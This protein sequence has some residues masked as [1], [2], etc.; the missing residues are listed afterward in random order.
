MR[1]TGGA[2]G[3]DVLAMV[4]ESARR[5]PSTTSRGP[6]SNGSEPPISSA[7]TPGWVTSA[8]LGR[9]ARRLGVDARGNL[10]GVVHGDR[11]FLSILRAR[12][13]SHIVNTASFAG[14]LPMPEVRTLPGSTPWSALNSPC[15][16]ES[17][18]SEP[19]PVCPRRAVCRRRQG[20][21]R[22]QSGR[23]H[24]IR[25]TRRVDARRGRPPP[26]FGDQ[27]DPALPPISPDA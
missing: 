25:D 7:T 19:A 23:I 14:T 4:T 6:L 21:R 3:D 2:A 8:T 17:S 24:R 15:S 13:D 5:K 1:S 11:A 20:G 12:H 22:R 27:R 10:M 16:W 18:C 9:S 26:T